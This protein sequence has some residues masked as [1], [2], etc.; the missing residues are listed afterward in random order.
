MMPSPVEE[1][2]ERPHLMDI[3]LEELELRPESDHMLPAWYQSVDY[4]ISLHPNSE[5]HDDIALP[6]DPP[7]ATVE[8]KYL[9]SKTV[10]PKKPTAQ[11]TNK[12]PYVPF[13]EQLSLMLDRLDTQLIAYVW[14]RKSSMRSEEVTLLGRALAPL[15]EYQLQ[16]KSTKWGVFDVADQSRVAELRLKYSVCTTP[17]A[18]RDPQQ[19]EAKQTEV[20]VTWEPPASDHGS[21]LTGYRIAILLDLPDQP[22][23]HTIC[24]LTNN[25]NPVY[26]V[27]NLTA[28]KAYWLDVRAV[29]KIG[30][31]D[32]C[33][34]QIS[35]APGQPTPPPKPW[36]DERRD[37]CFNVAWM[38]PKSGGGFPV[39][40]YRIKMRKI[41]GATKWNHMGE[42]KPVWI[43]MGTI[44]A[45]DKEQEGQPSM[46]NAWVGPLEPI[47]CEYRFQV[48]AT[49]KTGE[50]EGSELSD[51]EYT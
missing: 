30:A 31:G 19:A 26:V 34:L 20:T 47:H 4:F 40:S 10:A 28:N 33:E 13:N 35:T 45:C 8:G 22:H 23:W 51:P 24:E 36:V 5:H 1:H 7:R 49:N 11:R 39:T 48:F 43:D 16:R 9:V 38:P 32:S 6:R 17:A 37:G 3:D 41:L 50:S 18:P 14:G 15:H 29:N 27:T 21:P 2:E 42:S 44:A 12:H 25:L 46:Y